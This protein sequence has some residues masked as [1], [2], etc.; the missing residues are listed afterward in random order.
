MALSLSL[1]GV[2][3]TKGN[4]HKLS[5]WSVPSFYGE[6]SNE[7]LEGG[8]SWTQGL[9]LGARVRQ[10]IHLSLLLIHPR[11]TPLLLLPAAFRAPWLWPEVEAHRE[12]GCQVPG[13]ERT[14]RALVGPVTRV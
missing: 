6:T 5:A 12:G 13:L 10:T 3:A 1:W 2:I 4:E 8:V 9:Q 11:F 14:R 7:D